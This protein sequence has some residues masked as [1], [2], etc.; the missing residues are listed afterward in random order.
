MPNALTISRFAFA[1]AWVTLALMAPGERRVFAI[2]AMLAATTDFVDGRIARRLG[3]ARESGGWLDS[4][5]D[6]TFVLAALG[7]YARAGALPLYIPV[8]IAF[9]FAQYA[10]DSLWMYR[11]GRPVRSR[12]GHWGGIINYALVLALAFTKSG[13]T[14]R[15]YLDGMVPVVGLFYVA[16]IIERALAYRTRHGAPDLR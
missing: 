6:V 13:S 9:S 14:A 2:F 7:C 16:A 1:A 12:L 11:A 4:I 3:V 5:A 8:L 10:F 15:T